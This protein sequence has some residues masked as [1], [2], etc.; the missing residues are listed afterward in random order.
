MKTQKWTR[1]TISEVIRTFPSIKQFKKN[2]SGAYEAMKRHGWDD[3]KELVD[4]KADIQDNTPKWTPEHITELVKT[5]KSIAEFSQKY[6]RAYEKVKH[7]KWWGLIE[8]I[9]QNAV[10]TKWTRENIAELL[11]QYSSLY[12]FRS[13]NLN[14]YQAILSHGWF[15]LISQIPRMPSDWCDDKIKWSVYRWY[16]PERNAVYIGLTRQFSQRIKAE[17]KYSTTS[18]VK[19]F[20]TSTGCTYEVK[21]IYTDLSCDDA[22]RLE[23]DTIQRSRD[24]GYLVLNRSRGGTLGGRPVEKPRVN[25]YVIAKY[26]L[27]GNYI[28]SI[29][30]EDDRETVDKLAM[31]MELN[32]ECLHAEVTTLSVPRKTIAV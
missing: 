16:F 9:R 3:L 22:A 13:K 14:A 25:L 21:E 29:L 17:L 2:C 12:E 20:I 4:R 31:Q 10:A 24:E 27:D 11:K 19:D 18:P 7:K 15:D 8:S 28:G 6:P 5:C 26:G 30:S 32:G 23:I 1:E